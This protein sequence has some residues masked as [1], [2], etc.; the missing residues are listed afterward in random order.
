MLPQIRQSRRRFFDCRA[1]NKG[2]RHV[3][4]LTSDRLAA[5][6][7]S[8]AGG[9]KGFESPVGAEERGVSITHVLASQRDHLLVVRDRRQDV[10]ESKQLCL[11]VA[12]LHGQVERL[13]RPP[14]TLKER[15]CSTGRET[16]DLFTD[17]AH[18][19]F[20]GG[21]HFGHLH[22]TGCESEGHRQYTP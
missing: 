22:P 2:A 6:P 21:R 18:D 5:E 11:E 20:E 1:G 16:G 14:S 12:I 4:N 19:R 17:T 9:G 13:V 10:D 8:E 15:R 3:L 7:S